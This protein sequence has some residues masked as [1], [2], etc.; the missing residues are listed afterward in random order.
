M[1]A[2]NK[3]FVYRV[4]VEWKGEKKALAA[5]EGKPGLEVATPPEFKGHAGIWSPEDLFVEAVNVCVMTTFL[6]FAERA[7]LGLVGYRSEAEG[8]LE[9]G[10]E[11]FS[12]TEILVRPS[13]EV[14]KEEDRA[15][16]EELI[17]K[18]EGNCLISNSIK[19]KVSVE[20]S[21]AVSK[22]GG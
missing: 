2:R 9:R 7:E 17:E 13:I 14:T 21:I 6:S 19:S 20:P 4:S 1:E 22:A 12:F 18:A 3:V 8:K 10:A 5:S 15:K 11:G 16:A